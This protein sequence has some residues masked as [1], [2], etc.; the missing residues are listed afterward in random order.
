MYISHHMVVPSKYRQFVHKIMSNQPYKFT[1][2]HKQKSSSKLW[3]ASS[4]ANFIT[5]FIGKQ[6]CMVVIAV[7]SHL[8]C[9]L[10]DF[11]ESQGFSTLFLIPASLKWVVF[12]LMSSLLF[13]PPPCLP[14]LSQSTLI[15]HLLFTMILVVSK[16]YVSLHHSWPVH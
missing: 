5:L 4:Q 16:P 8:N 9:G 1:S 2:L 6:I 12:V 13:L 11:L 14:V 10:T 15:S 3:A 7:R